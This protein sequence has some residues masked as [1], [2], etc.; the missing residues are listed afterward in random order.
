MIKGWKIGKIFGISI[1]IHPSWLFIF[2]FFT[3][4]L[5]TSVFPQRVSGYSPI[6]YWFCG[7]ATVLVL[8]ICVIIHELAHSRVAQYFKI[9]VKRITLFALG[10]VAQSEGKSK[11]AKIEFLI[12]IA[13][14]LSSIALAGIFW[15]LSK[16]LNLGVELLAYSL[17]YLVL[18]NLILALFNLLPGYPM[19]GGRIVKAGIW[20]ISGDQLKAIKWATLL[21]KGVAFLLIIA[22]LFYLG[23]WIA[24]IGFV[25]LMFGGSEYQQLL[26]ERILTQGKVKDAM[27]E[28]PFKTDPKDV[29]VDVIC[30]PEDVLMDIWKK[31]VK[32]HVLYVVENNKIIGKIS[33]LDIEAYIIVKK[34]KS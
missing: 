17:G 30:V 8:F 13:G 16:V 15:I 24:F 32:Y 7:A 34:Q 20:K 28:F 12:A 1:E 29:A 9:P 31:M 6:S 25:L 19:D 4:A 22:G 23:L 3:F 2:G 26:N 18:I 27:E 5:A 11:S 10:G 14:P 33:K 21:G